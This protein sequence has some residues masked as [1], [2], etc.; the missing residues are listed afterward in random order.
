M[1]DILTVP[2]FKQG[3]ENYD[4]GPLCIR[5][6]VSYLTGR[7]VPEKEY[8]DTI[9]AL[10]MD[11]NATYRYGTPKKK[12]KWT[13]HQLDYRYRSIHGLKG[14]IS[15]VERDRLPVIVLG[16]MIDEYGTTYE[17]YVV[18]AGIRDRYLHINDPY[19]GKRQVRIDDFLTQKGNVFWKKRVQW[20]MVVSKRFLT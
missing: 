8:K 3:K 14:L 7:R 18:V 16:Y 12:M 2:Y 13:V 19:Y 9:L 1:N 4:C 20:G 10:S 6:V 5:M 15:V 17:H 11:G